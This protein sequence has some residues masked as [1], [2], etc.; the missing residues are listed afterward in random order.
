M[1]D[2]NTFL[3]VDGHSLLFRAFYA[4]DESKFSSGGQPTNAVY[5]FFS[6]LCEVV[7]K[8]RP[9]F[10]A[11]AFDTSGGTF[12]NELLPCY[13]AQRPKTP[14]SF[15]KQLEI[16]KKALDL[17]DVKWFV[18]KGFEGDDIVASLSRK[19]EE[20]GCRVLIVSGDKDVFQLID[21]KVS[22]IFPGRH[23]KDF[24]LKTPEAILE[25]YSVPP[26]LYP[27]LAALRGEGADNIPGVR[28]VG[29]KIAAKWLLEF[30]SLR[31]LLEGA[32][33]IKG[34]KGEEL[35]KDE[36]Q[37]LLNR[38]VNQLISDLSFPVPISGMHPRELAEGFEPFMESLSFGEKTIRKIEGSFGYS[39][40]RRADLFSLPPREGGSAYFAGPSPSGFVLYTLSGGKGGKWEN[41]VPE[42]LQE[43]E[44][45]TA[46]DYKGAMEK[47]GP[48]PMPESDLSLASYLMDPDHPKEAMAPAL[49][50]EGEER[51]SAVLRLAPAL[52]KEL[53]KRGEKELL[54][55]LE[56]PVA[57]ILYDMEKRGVLVDK[58]ALEEMKG[59]FDSQR[60]LSSALAMEA[61][62]FGHEEVNLNSPKQVANVL[63]G[64]FKIKGKGRSTSA[65]ALEKISA[66]VDPEG[67]EEK[68]IQALLKFREEG[69]LSE[70]ASSLLK[71][72][73]SDGR[74]YSTFDQKSTGTGR[75]ASQ[76]PNL[77]TIPNR[78]EEGR[79]IRS[80]FVA[81]EGWKLLSCD[82]SQIELRIMAD[83]SGDEKLIEAFKAGGDFHK[84]IAHLV[85]GVPEEEV[86]PDERASVKQVSYG[87]A[88]GLSAFGLAS[89]LHIPQKEAKK[90]EEKYF[91]IFGSVKKYLDLQTEEASRRGY[92]ETILGRRRYF[93]D[94]LSPSPQARRA[95]ERSARNAPIQ[96][97]AADIMKLAMIRAA[98]AL[99]ER[100]LK[101]RIVLQIHDELLVEV[102]PGEEEEAG[103][104][105]RM[106]MEGARELKVPLTV[107]MGWG[108]NW[109]QAAH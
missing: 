33:A 90:L 73:S 75:I 95:A 18:R 65:E 11:V 30:G 97:S 29:D 87:L 74:I 9:Y 10:I 8:Y 28:G 68:F 63:Y 98:K 107:S 7:D 71:A 4:L 99:E 3:I 57:K 12:R 1:K 61:L 27:D 76:D 88:Y 19:G 100:G 60:S 58:A 69:K 14:E 62:G 17:L 15:A 64:E 32:E 101:S 72:V 86:T 40:S 79:Q 43:G 51:L 21:G 36:E 24:S 106:A 92:S 23:F 47:A 89:R 20:E 6:M 41:E 105:I 42:I 56:M 53:E 45:W 66:A 104:S 91:S 39:P 54:H 59:F 77:Q 37:V 93:P 85:Y 67:P 48:L 50:K 13:K 25:A 44:G 70:I 102:A 38:R 34:A 35:R 94:L 83:L 46:L 22:V 16:V 78:T 49:E 5:G 96:G 52:E 80:A 31:N 82:Y 109:Q 55:G 2:S 81:P 103:E 108:E 84:Y 26:S